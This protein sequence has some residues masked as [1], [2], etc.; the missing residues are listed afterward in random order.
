MRK[1]KINEQQANMLKDLGKTKVLK[2][3]Q[4]QYNR[5]LEVERLVGMD[6]SESV[7]GEFKKALPASSRGEFNNTKLPGITES[8]ETTGNYEAFINELYG[9]NEGAETKYEKLC[10]LMESAGLINNNRLVKEKFRGDKNV[11]R[12][13]ITMGLNEMSEGGSEYSA[14]E[15]MEELVNSNDAEANENEDY[16]FIGNQVRDFLIKYNS[17]FADG[18]IK[19]VERLFNNGN[20]N[21]AW[22]TMRKFNKDG[23]LREAEEQEG[24][25]GNDIVKYPPMSQLRRERGDKPTEVKR[26]TIPSLDRLD[27]TRV[28][29]C[30]AE[31]PGYSFTSSVGKLIKFEGYIE[32]FKNKFNEEPIFKP[33][34]ENN[35]LDF[36]II[37]P[38]FTEARDRFK[39]GMSDAIDADPSLANEGEVDET[40]VAGASGMG[41]SSGPF[42][43]PMGSAPIN[44]KPNVGNELINDEMIDK[45]DVLSSA[46]NN[47][48]MIINSGSVN[49][50]K[51]VDN[52]DK[53]IE[54]ASIMSSYDDNEDNVINQKLKH[55]SSK[56]PMMI[57][58]LIGIAEHTL[59]NGIGED[60]IEYSKGI[61]ELLLFIKRNSGSEITEQGIGNSGQYDTPGLEDI[62]MKGDTPRGS[63]P[64]WKKPTIAGGTEVKIKDKCSKF[65]Y[66]N[67]GAEAL[68]EVAKRTGRD[69]SEIKE[70]IKNFKQ[71]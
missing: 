61:Y 56:L 3:T 50:G 15:I 1:I 41:G 46:V 65:P 52:S 26:V 68:A 23:M 48:L 4:E 33:T 27:G 37:N 64:T 13:I 55:L 42:V 16:G 19:Y 66:C 31:I 18:N 21:L 9:M 60:Y 35:F 36:D 47:L 57:N 2:V 28:L 63:G 71:K 29:S 14:M 53:L 49:P 11:V 59:S 22:T 45:V 58:K 44:R 10:K 43:A 17:E 25:V 69:I 12:E 34:P 70:I 24:I 38:V 7:D 30:R 8:E 51:I 67:Q 54:F 39:N 5:I 62:N 20:Y 40:T 6:L 32:A